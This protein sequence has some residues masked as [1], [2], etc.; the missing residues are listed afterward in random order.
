MKVPENVKCIIRQLNN[1]GHDAYAVGGCV[2]DTILGR[3]PDDWDITTDA[4]PEEVKAVFKK[5]VD[6]GLL[7][8]TVTVLMN[9][10]GYEVTTYRIDGD[11]GDG[12]HPDNVSFTPD[13]EEDLKRR[14]FTVNA[15]AYN[16]ETGYV[17]CFGGVEDIENRIIRCVGNPDERFSEDALRIMRAV[18]FSGQLE[19]TIEDDTYEAIKRHVDNLKNVS[20]ERIRVEF[21]KLLM[22]VEPEKFMML[23]DTGITKIILPEFDICMDTEQNTPHHIYDVGNHTIH[24]LINLNYFIRHAKG[25]TSAARD[26]EYLEKQT[27]GFSDSE[28]D[29]FK[30][31]LEKILP[32]TDKA[33]S[34][35]TKKEEKILA[36]TMLL[37]DIAKP[38]CK[39]TDER[40]DHFKGH[41][42]VSADMSKEILRRLKF[43]NETIKSVSHLVFYHDYRTPLVKKNI[44]RGL[45]K[46]GKDYMGLFNVVTASDI[47][48]QS[49]ELMMEKCDR[50]AGGAVI[51][52]EIILDEECISLKDLC[53]TGSDLI[54]DG[55]KPG[56][57]IG[58]VLNRLLDMVIDDPKLN[59]YEV[60]LSKS[61]EWREG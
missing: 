6:T 28:K 33:L 3:L 29:S 41:P 44:R 40:G 17:D 9:G 5:T 32:V 25:E 18:R 26:A 58:E 19:F 42:A 35:V 49:P 8:G 46:I 37:H 50:I 31:C 12:R 14:D 43:D 10:E 24:A 52:D 36:F 45:S 15:I 27:E 11:Y 22:S 51:A 23:Y 30:K 4:K 16:D 21:E 56:P 13:L 34:S 20:A 2:R 38:R 53:I 55:M 48:A 7:H 54:K 60:L 39:T 59:D 57:G 61:R 47:M 1:A